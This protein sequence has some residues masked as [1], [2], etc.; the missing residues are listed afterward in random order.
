MTDTLKPGSYIGSDGEQRTFEISGSAIA[1]P[2][3]GGHHWICA[4]I[5]ARAAGEALIA[6]ADEL[7]TEY[8]ELSEDFRIAIRN[9][10]SWIEYLGASDKWRK[11]EPG[12]TVMFDRVLA[13]FRAGLE[14]GRA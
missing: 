2:C 5:D 3:Y 4:T 9:G 8:V 14:R 7:E 11:S 10:A 1:A 13:A 6:L 12:E